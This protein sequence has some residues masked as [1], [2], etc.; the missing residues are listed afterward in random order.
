MLKLPK[1]PVWTW[2]PGANEPTLAAQLHHDGHRAGLLVYTDSYLQQ[3]GMRLLDPSSLRPYRRG[4]RVGQT[5]VVVQ[6]GGFPS[7][8]LD[9]AP[10]GYGKDALERKHGR[11]LNTLQLLELGPADGVG[12]IEVCT[13]IERKLG[14]QAPKLD[15]L[16]HQCGI[17]LKPDPR[18]PS[19]LDPHSL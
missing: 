16:L 1:T 8:I 3:P 7:V 11:E 19:N 13:D 5:P 15:D 17:A 18:F 2:L 4:E 10:S 12:A 6:N 9:A 14:W